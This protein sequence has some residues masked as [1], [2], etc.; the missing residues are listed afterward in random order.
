MQVALGTIKMDGD[1]QGR[2]NNS[3]G[4]R[5]GDPNVYTVILLTTDVVIVIK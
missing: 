1:L 3:K 5:T 2:R 4:L